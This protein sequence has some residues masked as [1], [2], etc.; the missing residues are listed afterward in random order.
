MQAFYPKELV[1]YIG[2]RIEQHREGQLGPITAWKDCLE[3]LFSENVAKNMICMSEEFIIH[4]KNR[5]GLGVNAYNV[6][7]V[8]AMLKKIGV[9]ISELEKAVAFE[10]MPM[11]PMRS[12]QVAFNEKLISASKGMLAPLTGR[13]LFVSVGTG[14]TTQFFK[15]AKAGCASSEP[16]LADAAS[17]GK[18]N[19]E[20]LSRDSRFKTALTKGWTWTILP[21]QAEVTWPHLPDLAQRALN[22]SNN[23][24]SLMSE[25]DVCVSIAEFA[26]LMPPGSSFDSCVE[27]VKLN[28]PPCQARDSERFRLTS[29]R[30][31]RAPP[32]G[33]ENRKHNVCIYVY[34]CIHVWICACM[35]IYICKCVCTCTAVFLHA[36]GARACA[37][38]GG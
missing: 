24:A 18:L 23:V 5:S 7:R 6:H 14:H 29:P 33:M 26:E 27:A 4:P 13:E 36:A 2:S 20:S 28:Q 11:E 1:D 9:D 37:A 34:M 22:A 32:R 21:W 35:F 31:M 12:N 15:A 10:R 16:T 17:G 25:L 19:A 8:G 38:Q 3:R 30:S